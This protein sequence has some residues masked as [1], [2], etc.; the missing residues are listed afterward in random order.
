MKTIKI[1]KVFCYSALCIIA[2]VLLVL[3]IVY[4]K[5]VNTCEPIKLITSQTSEKDFCIYG[6]SPLNKIYK[7]PYNNECNCYSSYYSFYNDICIEVPA[8][9]QLTSNR[10]FLLI[11]GDKKFTF[12]E[13]V[14]SG[15][16]YLKDSG[17]VIKYSLIKKLGLRTSFSAKIFSVFHWVIFKKIAG[18]ILIAPFLMFLVIFKR[19]ILAFL[20]KL[21]KS[22]IIATIKAIADIHKQLF[23]KLK[24]VSFNSYSLFKNFTAL[25][26]T[27]VFSL[28]KKLSTVNKIWVILVILS[29]MLEIPLYLINHSTLFTSVWLIICSAFI[30][31]ILVFIFITV[32]LRFITLLK[33]IFQF[34]FQLLLRIAAHITISFNRKTVYKCL[35]ITAF[36]IILAFVLGEILLRITGT[37]STY[38]EKVFGFYNYNSEPMHKNTWLLTRP[39]NN[40]TILCSKGE[41][42]NI[43]STNSLG[44][45]DKEPDTALFRKAPLIIGIGDSFTEGFGVDQDSTWLKWLEYDLHKKGFASYSFMNAGVGG[46]DIIY[47]YMLFER[48][49]LK[50]KPKILMV[51]I[52]QSDIWDIT[53]RGGFERFLPNGVTKYRKGPEWEWL[54]EH[55]HLVRFYV[56]H[57]LK[58]NQSFLSD[59]ELRQ[60]SLESVHIINNCILKFSNLSKKYNFNLIIIVHPLFNEIINH[61]YN[62]LDRTID[63]CKK[64]NISYIDMLSHFNNIEKINEKNVSLYHYKDMHYNKEGYKAFARGVLQYMEDSVLSNKR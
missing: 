17:I 58:L 10:P 50:Y 38:C 37:F 18:I 34:I 1:I 27:L 42:F 2:A 31:T 39:R 55:F 26:S 54:Y 36:T 46:S 40:Y 20:Y 6:I 49:L 60:K 53:Q 25:K 64:N 52:N 59:R 43:R 5:Q 19:I 28:F 61:K 23:K 16:C 30:I 45:S 41:Y 4:L 32:L 29:T 8:T 9:K 56:Y 35:S 7:F 48:N 63:F 33:K 13:G 12:S 57:F 24:K 47:E 15:N 3:L 62:M 22:F 51:A 21:Y 14:N 11:I 44:L